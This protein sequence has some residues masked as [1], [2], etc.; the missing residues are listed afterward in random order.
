MTSGGTLPPRC[1]LPALLPPPRYSP[2]ALLRPQRV[3][4]QYAPPALLPPRRS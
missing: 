1:C 4:L 2:A 3:L